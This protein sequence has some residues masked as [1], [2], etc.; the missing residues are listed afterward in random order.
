MKHHIDRFSSP[1][2]LD[3]F[4]EDLYEAMFR[5]KLPVTPPTGKS[6]AAELLGYEKYQEAREA[7][8][9]RVKMTHHLVDPLDIEV[10]KK[11]TEILDL[12]GYCNDRK[13]EY[14]FWPQSVD[15]KGI[16]QGK[17]GHPAYTYTELG[18]PLEQRIVAHAC[19]KADDG[20]EVHF[21]A[22]PLFDA[23]A[24]QDHRLPRTIA[25]IIDQRGC[26][27]ESLNWVAESFL[28]M[29]LGLDVHT[30]NLSHAGIP[31][32]IEAC[33]EKQRGSGDESGPGYKVQVNTM[34]LTN[35][36]SYQC[37]KFLAATV[38]LPVMTQPYQI[39][40]CDSDFQV[41]KDW[42]ITDR[43][44]IE[45]LCQSRNLRYTVF[46]DGGIIVSGFKVT[47][48]SDQVSLRDYIWRA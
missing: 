19:L 27:T 31:R 5:R 35:W 32:L 7:V 17:G 37:P 22:A 20:Q 18:G 16:K 42:Q 13:C 25:E 40:N 47:P 39:R 34:S 44:G 21:D 33:R 23:L 11:C 28:K 15:L 45:S 48:M 24:L 12:I 2:D 38:G 9:M 3:Q 6:V 30:R 43:K 41:M 14:F 36:V 4:A 10:C 26:F 46:D 29:D 8:R 1:E